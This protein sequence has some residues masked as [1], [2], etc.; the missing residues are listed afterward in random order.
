MQ[1]W[2]R[3]PS[4]LRSPLGKCYRSAGGKSRP[5]P[6]SPADSWHAVEART[7]RAVGGCASGLCALGAARSSG[8]CWGHMLAGPARAACRSLLYSNGNS[9]ICSLAARGQM[10][11]PPLTGSVDFWGPECWK[12]RASP[13]STTWRQTETSVDRAGRPSA[14]GAPCAQHR[15][16]NGVFLQG[17]SFLN[18]T[19]RAFGNGFPLPCWSSWRKSLWEAS[20]CGKKLTLSFFGLAHVQ[21]WV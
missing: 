13:R 16:V 2:P 20:V 10:M 7:G 17:R 21:Y 4:P 9:T 1:S 6:R 3:P 11:C 12:I 5:P 18:S 8:P 14:P 19:P 15:G